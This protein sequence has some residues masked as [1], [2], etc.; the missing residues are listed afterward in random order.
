[1]FPVD[2]IYVL[3][4]ETSWRKWQIF[5][6]KAGRPPGPPAVV[7]SPCFFPTEPPVLALP[8]P[9]SLPTILWNNPNSW[10]WNTVNTLCRDNDVIVFWAAE[11]K[12][13]LVAQLAF[14]CKLALRLLLL[15]AHWRKLQQH[16]CACVTISLRS[17]FMW[18]SWVPGCFL[19]GFFTEVRNWVSLLETPNWGHQSTS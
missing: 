17:I 5:A 3:Q 18:V 13:T 9:V 4:S 19:L 14:L 15:L 16:K 1:M 8:L 6:N 2:H 11:C 7:I 12:A 10:G